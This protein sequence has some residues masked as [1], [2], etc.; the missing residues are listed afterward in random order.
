MVR[1]NFCGGISSPLK[2][3]VIACTRVFIV[4]CIIRVAHWRKMQKLFGELGV[5]FVINRSRVRFPVWVMLCN[6]CGKVDFFGDDA[7]FYGIT[8]ISCCT[9]LGG[10]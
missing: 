4:R 2:S 1:G 6:D 5:G 3:I 8:S 10:L 7:A 9:E